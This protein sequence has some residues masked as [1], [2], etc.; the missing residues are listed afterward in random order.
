MKRNG[1][2]KMGE[3]KG[4]R[5]MSEYM[6]RKVNVKGKKGKRNVK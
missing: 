3:G 2:G 4:K 5:R 1:K 6:S